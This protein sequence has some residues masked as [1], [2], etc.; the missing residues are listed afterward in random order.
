[1]LV[2]GKQRE[3]R[4]YVPALLAVLVLLALL[5]LPAAG[6]PHHRSVTTTATVVG[7][8][9]SAATAAAAAVDFSGR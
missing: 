9:G 1:M 5:R 8:G 6:L 7:L 3:K 4:D 2:E